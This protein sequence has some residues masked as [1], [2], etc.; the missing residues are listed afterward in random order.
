MSFLNETL[1]EAD[2]L[3]AK[4]KVLD[5]MVNIRNYCKGWQ[6][7]KKWNCKRLFLSGINRMHQVDIESD[8][9]KE[10]LDLPGL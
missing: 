2:T 3:R 10:L 1:K 9:Y 6:A 8:R 7:S 4:K 5:Q